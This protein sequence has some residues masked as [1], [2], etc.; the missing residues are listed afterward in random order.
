MMWYNAWI[1]IVC[2]ASAQPIHSKVSS[3]RT[4]R[5]FNRDFTFFLPLNLNIYQ[6]SLL[7]IFYLSSLSLISLFFLFLSF[8]FLFFYR[9]ILPD[10][11]CGERSKV[12]HSGP[13]PH[14]PAVQGRSRVPSIYPWSSRLRNRQWQ[15]KGTGRCILKT[16]SLKDG[17]R[18]K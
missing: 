13:P 17:S 4:G 16:G 12:P 8:Y 9:H 1:R 18:T 2:E 14:L 3:Q 5:K 6:K 10:S 7:V 15:S 11:G